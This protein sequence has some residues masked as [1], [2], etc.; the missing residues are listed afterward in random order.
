MGDT[1]FDALVLIALL[2][3][4]VAVAPAALADGAQTTTVT[5]ESTTIDFVSETSVSEDG[6]RYNDTVSVHNSTG[7]ELTAGA[8][9]DWL[10]TTGNVTWHDT[11]STSDGEQATITYS[12]DQVTDT[13][14]QLAAFISVFEVPLALLILLALGAT[15]ILAWRN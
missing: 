1:K 10:P 3:F 11:A 7:E 6:V 9:Y 13:T 4:I 12:A 14:A 15:G 5:N 8:D 2:G